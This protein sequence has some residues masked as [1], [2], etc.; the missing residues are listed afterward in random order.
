MEN[1]ATSACCAQRSTSPHRNDEEVTKKEEPIETMQTENGNTEEE[2]IMCPLF[3][4]GLPSD[5]STNP[6][7]AALAS[8]IV[9]NSEGDEEIR[10]S[11]NEPPREATPKAGGGRLRS[12]K[13]R[14][15]RRQNPYPT[16][17]Q[18]QSAN[19]KGSSS[20]G[21]TQLFLKMWKL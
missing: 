19:D 2:Q 4:E 11:G 6:H 5:F 9:D 15:R 13:S 12:Q 17:R 21:E 8:L 3:M 18:Q 16:R 14:T 20:I 10:K 1:A 7:L